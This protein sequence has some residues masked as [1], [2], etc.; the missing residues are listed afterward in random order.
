LSFG[1]FNLL[2]SASFF[3]VVVITICDAFKIVFDY[4]RDL[5]IIPFRATGI[6]QAL[7]SEVYLG[8]VL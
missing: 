4:G 3:L 7:T 2:F 1:I 5:S 8:V 6:F